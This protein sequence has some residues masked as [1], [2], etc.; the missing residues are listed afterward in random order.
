MSVAWVSV[1]AH[2]LVNFY[3][4]VRIRT[5]NFSQM[6]QTSDHPVSHESFDQNLLGRE[7]L[8]GDEVP[9]DA[10][11]PEEGGADPLD[12]ELDPHRELQSTLPKRG[13]IGMMISP[14]CIQLR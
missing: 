14:L 4:S 6:G 8:D 5:H 11:D 2:W 3:G 10:E 12:E 13:K 9:D 7:N 1:Q